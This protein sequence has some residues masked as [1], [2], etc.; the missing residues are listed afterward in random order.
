MF[1][2]GA[3]AAAKSQRGVGAQAVSAAARQ[4]SP[5]PPGEKREVERE[6]GS[7]HARRQHHRLD[8]HD[9]AAPRGVKCTTYERYDWPQVA[10][11]VDK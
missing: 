10:V 1:E 5:P 11:R 8:R 2:V 3:G 4:Q 6:R 7:R 9:A